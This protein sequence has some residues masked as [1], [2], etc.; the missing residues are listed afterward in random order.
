LDALA[1]FAG[2]TTIIVGLTIAYVSFSPSLGV[3]GLV[4]TITWAAWLAILGIFMWRKTNPHYEI[5]GSINILRSWVQFP[6]GLFL[7]FEVATALK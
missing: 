7:L 1:I 5:K 2:A 6:L 4:L 3:L